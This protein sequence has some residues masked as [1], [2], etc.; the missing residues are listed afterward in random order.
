MQKENDFSIKTTA[1]GWDDIRTNGGIE[2]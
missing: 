2:D 1:E